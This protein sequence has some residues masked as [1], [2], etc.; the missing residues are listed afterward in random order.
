MNQEDDSVIQADRGTAAP[1]G[2]FQKFTHHVL[3]HSATFQ[4]FVEDFLSLGNGW[5]LLVATGISLVSLLMDG[6]VST[7]SVYAILAFGLAQVFGVDLQF[8]ACAIRMRAAYIAHDWLPMILWFLLGAFLG[9]SIWQAVYVF[10]LETSSHMTEAQAFAYIGIDYLRWLGMR[11]ALVVV[12]MVVAAILRHSRTVLAQGGHY[13]PTPGGGQPVTPVTQFAIAHVPSPDQAAPGSA[14]SPSGKVRVPAAA[15]AV[16]SGGAISLPDPDK[17]KRPAAK[18]DPRTARPVSQQQ[19]QRAERERFAQ[20]YFQANPTAGPADLARALEIKP[21]STVQRL[22]E[23]FG[24][25]VKVVPV[26]D[27]TPVAQSAA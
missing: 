11:A 19:Q 12:L 8:F 9:Y 3:N 23:K 20:F 7:T 24:N 17:V 14:A 2:G 21:G 5:L 1:M 18:R 13:P 25:P 16:R 15:A 27:P 4:Q 26:L 22:W 6:S 10:S